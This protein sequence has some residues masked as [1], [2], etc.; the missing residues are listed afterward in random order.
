M[1]QVNK[2]V[3]LDSKLDHIARGVGEQ[4]HEIEISSRIT[5]RASSD[6]DKILERK[7][8]SEEPIQFSFHFFFPN[9]VITLK[10]FNE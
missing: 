4:T 8:G 10:M 3:Q 1:C 2:R 5:G 7:K 6:T 9:W